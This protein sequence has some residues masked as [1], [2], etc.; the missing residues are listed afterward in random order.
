MQRGVRRVWG[1]EARDVRLEEIER[2]EG[3]RSGRIYMD[4]DLNNLDQRILLPYI[5]ELTGIRHIPN[6]LMPISNEEDSS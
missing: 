1:E 6:I 3:K 2:P 4:T 5:I